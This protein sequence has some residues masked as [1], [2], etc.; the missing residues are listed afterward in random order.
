[1]TLD[2]AAFVADPELIRALEEQSTP[3]LCNEDRVLFHQGDAPVG[4]FILKSGNV[5]LSM[6][7]N[8]GR[9]VLSF[10]AQV[11]SLLGLPGL[12][13]DEPYSLSA[14]AHAGV[15]LRYVT[16][17]DFASMMRTQPTL[18]LKVLQV[19]A[20]EVR[21]ARSAVIQRLSSPRRKP[22]N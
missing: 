4:L 1:M 20:A 2:P 13:G 11:G 12:I 18:A 7:S 17:D 15:E 19:L 10:Q 8:S 22:V 3:I 9:E 21:A 6:K 14:T 5:T 16:R